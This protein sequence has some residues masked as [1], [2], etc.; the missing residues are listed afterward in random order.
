MVLLKRSTYQLLVEVIKSW[1]VA[2]SLTEP[3][4]AIL[5]QK[6]KGEEETQ[7]SL[8]KLIEAPLL[9]S[10]W[11]PF[12]RTWRPPITVI[13]TWLAS[14][15]ATKYLQQ[16][17]IMLDDPRLQRRRLSQDFPINASWKGLISPKPRPASSLLLHKLSQAESTNSRPST[18]LLH[19]KLQQYSSILSK[20][21]FGTHLVDNRC[22]E[23]E[24]R[25][26]CTKVDLPAKESLSLPRCKLGPNLPQQRI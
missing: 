11:R 20:I 15:A 14:D 21:A 8:R 10:H 18:S 22:T 25:T 4:F 16:A 13:V 19:K 3:L 9:T 2:S 17:C 6:I 1:S 12:L 24:R 5:C 26:T 23:I 7:G